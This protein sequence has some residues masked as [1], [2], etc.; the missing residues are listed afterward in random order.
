MTYRAWS[1]LPT[2]TSAASQRAAEQSRGLSDRSHSRPAA[3]EN[4]NNPQIVTCL[5]LEFEAWVGEE[6]NAA[7]CSS[8]NS[9]DKGT[10]QG[11][12]T[13]VAEQT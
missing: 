4:S 3:Q 9:L 1:A 10:Q 2:T 11:T 5:L 12:V 7:W 8:T 6:F 13:Q